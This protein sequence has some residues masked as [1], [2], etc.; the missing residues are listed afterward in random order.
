MINFYLSIYD[1]YGTT[2]SRVI[3]QNKYKIS[4]NYL[5]QLING[6]RRI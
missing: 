3:V 6:S 4:R 2:L 1:I 5:V